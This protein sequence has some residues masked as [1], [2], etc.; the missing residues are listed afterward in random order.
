MPLVRRAVSL[1]VPC[2]R[3]TSHVHHTPPYALNAAADRGELSRR[4]VKVEDR[5]RI[6]GGV[7]RETPPRASRAATHGA[8]LPVD[9]PIANFYVHS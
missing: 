1:Q 3:A 9:R 7:R 2:E 5:P 8:A 6:G 4:G